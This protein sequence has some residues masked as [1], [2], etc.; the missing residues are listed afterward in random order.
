MIKS[1]PPAWGK[2]KL[3]VGQWMTSRLN[4]THNHYSWHL[5]LKNS[6]LSFFILNLFYSGIDL[7]TS[8]HLAFSQVPE[9]AVI[10]YVNK[11]K[12]KFEYLFY[13][14]RYAKEGLPFPEVGLEHK[15]YL[16]QP[17]S[18]ILRIF[19]S[20]LD[21]FFRNKTLPDPYASGY[22]YKEM[23]EGKSIFFSLVEKKGFYRRFVK[24][25]TDPIEYIIEA[26]KSIDRPIF[27]IP[28][29]MFFGKKSQKSSQKIM[30]ILFGP[31][32]RPGISRKLFTLFR[33]P[34]KIFIEISKPVDLKKFLWRYEN[35]TATNEHLAL[36]L[37]RNLLNQIN[38][39]RRNI[40]GPVLKSRQELKENILTSDRLREYM[41]HYAENKDLPIHK[42][43]REANEYLD[44]IAANFSLTMIKVLSAILRWLFNVMFDGVIMNEN[45]L[46]KIKFMSLKGPLVLVP[47]HKSHIDYLILSYLLYR[48]N[49]QCPHIA[50]GKNLSFW[51][52][53]PIFRRGGAFFIRRTFKGAILYSKIFSE[54]VYKILEEGF[55]IEFFIEGTRS[56]T[57]KLLSPKLGF[58]SILLNAYK[59]GACYDLIFV[60]V[61]VGYDRVLEESSYL[62]ELEGAQKKSENLSQL[63]KARKFLKK[64]YGKIYIKFHDP[65]SLNAL[66]AKEHHQFTGM[67]QKEQNLF[68]RE[69]GHKMVNA[70]DENTVVTPHSLVASA[71]LNHASNRFSYTALM[72]QIKM[73]LN[74]LSRQK[75]KLADTLLVDHHHAIGTVLEDYLQ[76]KFIEAAAE[77][78]HLS[79]EEANYLINENKRPGLEY[80]KNNSIIFFIPMAFTALAI[81]KRDAFQF[82]TQDIYE[83]YHFLQDLFRKEFAH[84][85]DMTPESMVGR[86]INAYIDEAALVPN[87][88]LPDTYNITSA[89]F[90]KLKVFSMFLASYLESYLV[91][92]TFFQEHPDNSLPP[93]DRIKKIQVLGAQMYK[94]KVIERKEALS[95]PY[96]DNAVDVFLSNGF[97]KLDEQDK[98]IGCLKEI[99]HYLSVIRA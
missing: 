9:D 98:I 2:V 44:E 21:Y 90:R 92:I 96:Y 16:W 34:E 45:V 47:C 79:L 51:P 54:Y 25:K 82:S 1:I 19:F 22:I 30:D 5:N 29:L 73:Y 77:N 61:Y 88:N 14:S 99:E 17:V 37:R 6:R 65:L 70:I 33:T 72:S 20:H 71:I 53:G 83:D 40:V 85:L 86:C 89:G 74:C 27:I 56:R 50:A 52:L 23:A 58:L 80:Y 66:L 3:K 59:N 42:V 76:T 49:M 67:T 95:K 84:N 62:K 87:P 39:H 60:P 26:Q 68:C 18:Q 91:A 31:T 4:G 15:T 8:Q 46:N 38:R 12:S 55:N 24:D 69:L 43:N 75:A 97:K 63:I 28:Q 57:G 94:N 81:L 64:R 35:K 32:T 48:H 11:F 10:V 78:K 13:H 93:K 36:I 41:A 7:K